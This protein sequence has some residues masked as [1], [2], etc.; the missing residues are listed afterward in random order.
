MREFPDML[1]RHLFF[2]ALLFT[3][4]LTHFAGAADQPDR[5]KIAAAIPE[6]AFAEP[7]QPRKI[8]VFSVTRGFRHQSI[9]WGVAAF[10]EMGEK[11]GAFTAVTSD[12]LANFEKDKLDTFD[13]VVF[14]N[15]TQ[16]VFMPAKEEWAKMDEAARAEAKEREL[17]LRA[18]FLCFIRSGKGFVGIHA[19]TDTFY[20][21]PEFGFMIGAYFDGHPWTAKA[22]VSIK[23]EKPDHPINRGLRGTTHLEFKEECYQFKKPYESD[24]Q[25]VLLRLDTERTNMNV[26][27]IKRTDNDFPMSWVRTHGQG[28]IYYS[29]LGHNTHIYENPKV[30]AHYLAGIQWAAGDLAAPPP[31]GDP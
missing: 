22:D 15:T 19:A 28:R 2:K 4:F 9:P 10:E 12:D 3:A 26:K 14:N 29:A 27:G 30:L 17:R 5:A 18:N 6:K 24:R 25:D 16:N 20:E 8:L 23:V 31:P 1:R 13:V 7:K 11:T 21:W